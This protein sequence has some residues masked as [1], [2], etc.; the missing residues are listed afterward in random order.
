MVRPSHFVQAAL[1]AASVYLYFAEL[2]LEGQ[3]IPWALAVIPLFLGLYVFIQYPGPGEGVG[4]QA[5]TLP[6]LKLVV[7]KQATTAKEKRKQ[8]NE[9][10]KELPLPPLG[11][12][13]APLAGHAYLIVFFNTSRACLKSALRVDQITRRL[14]SKWFH[15]L[16]VSRDD[17]EA[18]EH[19]VSRWKG[20]AT[21]VAH[22]ATEA[23]S[24]NYIAE[25]RAFA[26]PHAFLIGK[27]GIIVWHGQINRPEVGREC[28]AMI[29]REAMTQEDG[30]VEAKKVD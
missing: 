13:G 18:L 11:K 22:D 3:P 19:A 7:A 28:A 26:F 23:A 2:E 29:R 9:E 8:A 25:H 6:A 1:Y 27:D 30:K 4:K 16:L 17:V 12:D 24:V 5:G 21:P 15:S 14:P 10:S 20:R